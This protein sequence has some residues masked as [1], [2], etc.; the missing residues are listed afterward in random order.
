MKESIQSAVLAI[1]PLRYQGEQ[2]L[3]K[4][5]PD[6]LISFK[7]LLIQIGRE[8][9]DSTDELLLLDYDHPYTA[10]VSFLES[11]DLIKKQKWKQEWGP[12]PVQ[13]IFHLHKKKEPP[14]LFRDST[15]SLW[16]ALQAEALYVTRVLKLQWVQLFA[17]KNLPVYQ[18]VDGEE[19]LARLTFSGD[20]SQLKREKLLPSRYLAGQGTNKECFYCGMSNHVPSK[21]PTKM[22]DMETRGISLVGY[23]P[24]SEIDAHFQKVFTHQKK[25]EDLLGSNIGVAEIRK[26]PALQVFLAYFDVYLVYQARFLGYIAFSVHPAWDG[27]GKIDRVKIDSRNLHTGLDCLR[28][29]QYKEAY[30]LMVVE[31]QTIAGKQFYATVG[32]AFIALERG[33]WADMGQFLQ[34]AIGMASTEKEK[35][36]IS[37]LLSRYHSLSGHP[38]KAEEIIQS[39]ANLYIDCQEVL[40][41]KIQTMVDDGLGQQ[42]LQLLRKLAGGD[43]QYFMAILFDPALMPVTDMTES[44]LSALVQVKQKEARESL[45]TAQS[46]YAE[47]KNWFACEDEDLQTNLKVLV[48]LEEQFARRSLYDVIDVVERSKALSMGSSRLRENKLDELNSQVDEAVLTWD[49]FNNYWH[50]YPYKSFF[51]RFQGCLLAGKRKLVEARS[52]AGENLGEARKRKKLG[53]SYIDTARSMVD[54]MQKL[55][56]VFDT[57]KIFGKKL[58]KA[59]LILTGVM[60]LIFPLITVLLAD[61]LSPRLVML[62]SDSVFK[63]ECLFVANL[64]VAPFFAFAATL[65]AVSK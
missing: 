1:R 28:V 63:R 6:F 9:K 54:H 53:L 65:R 46:D 64:L 29:G 39:V 61:Q 17:D 12:I 5:W 49:K 37:L 13:V 52:V 60:L 40:Y 34:L 4:Q 21:C 26:H 36:Y 48:N 47:L 11:L 2:I 27:S 25:M 7:K 31:N 19:G 3:K 23:L 20:L 35:I 56:V 41:R 55:K 30:E 43:R 24:F 50:G 10:L 33:R 57:L 15:A 44:M 18:F 16:S 62:A 58:I 14:P 45:A 22:M 51:G 8:A 42:A 59:E 38:W 32:Q